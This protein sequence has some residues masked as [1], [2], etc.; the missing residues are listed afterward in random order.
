MSGG[1]IVFCDTESTSLDRRTREIWEVALVRREPGGAETEWGALVGGGLGLRHATEESLRVG[2]FFER[3][4]AHG[5]KS[6]LPVLPE[7]EVACQVAARLEGAF[8]V[9]AVS[10]F[11]DTG[12]F[13]LLDRYGLIPADG[14][15]PWHY[16]LVCVENL[17]AGLLGVEP[18]W[19][20]TELSLAVGVDPA[21]FDRHTATGDVRW[22]IAI[23]DAVI[24][25]AK[26]N[27]FAARSQAERIRELTG[28]VDLLGGENQET[29]VSCVSCVSC[30][31]SYNTV[32]VDGDNPDTPCPNCGRLALRD[33][34]TRVD[35]A[36]R[37]FMRLANGGA[38]WGEMETAGLRVE[39]ALGGA[40]EAVDATVMVET[41]EAAASDA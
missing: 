1:P 25:L 37:E 12:L 9:G 41:A 35:V 39:S 14:E 26:V 28:L 29:L 19:N 21:E 31:L 27:R 38:S 6:D 24:A 10:S 7:D 30:H 5:G 18:P 40:A 22:A 23:Y 33:R 8:L 15:P 16:H 13:K 34:L 11:E 32:N 2:G 36:V 4:P 17:A 20:S 3:H